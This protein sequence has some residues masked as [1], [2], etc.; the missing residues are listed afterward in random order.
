MKFFPLILACALAVSGGIMRGAPD[1]GIEPDAA[2]EQMVNGRIAVNYYNEYLQEIV[3]DAR[4]YLAEELTGVMERIDQF[5]AEG[6]YDR[7]TPGFPGNWRNAKEILNLPT[8]VPN[9][10]A[11]ADLKLFKDGIDQIKK[12]TDELSKYAGN[13]RVIFN[14]TAVGKRINAENTPA[15][16]RT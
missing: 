14:T 13:S 2:Y 11:A 4:H 12:D 9:W 5:I 10:Y 15:S 6:K 8:R 3:V 1:T 7:G 16:N